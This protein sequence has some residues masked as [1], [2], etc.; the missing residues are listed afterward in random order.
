M[1]LAASDLIA[2]G[3]LAGV[4][5]HPPSAFVQARA[6]FLTPAKRFKAYIKD[7]LP[8]PAYLRDWEVIT[9]AVG[10]RARLSS[11]RSVILTSGP[12][13]NTSIPKPISQLRLRLLTE[14]SAAAVPCAV[15]HGGKFLGLVPPE[16]A[17]NK[18]TSRWVEPP[19][20]APTSNAM[21]IQPSAWFT[22]HSA[23]STF[24]RVW[25][26]SATLGRRSMRSLP[27]LWLLSTG[28]RVGLKRCRHRSARSCD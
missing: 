18:I 27:M 10:R 1:D 17:A 26:R 22:K 14:P 21:R 16:M 6:E 11:R 28:R 9:A 24:P 3:K 20:P 19:R 12:T 7:Q 23:H 4:A 8:R 15:V 25:Y 5:L 2:T 13:G